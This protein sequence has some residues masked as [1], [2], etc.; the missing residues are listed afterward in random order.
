[1]KKRK[2]DQD[3]IKTI[4][5]FIAQRYVNGSNVETSDIGMSAQKYVDIY[6]DIFARLENYN[7]PEM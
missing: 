5:H 7:N 3:E 2:F 6:Q 1:M 4:A